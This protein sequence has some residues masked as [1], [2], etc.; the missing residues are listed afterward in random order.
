MSTVKFYCDCC[1]R[2]RPVEIEPSQTD[3]ITR[4][5]IWAD[6]VCTVCRLVIMTITADEPGIYDF[7]KVG[8]LPD[9]IN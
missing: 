3:E 7:V 4:P 5:L 8:E 1:E 2:H 9:D 6:I